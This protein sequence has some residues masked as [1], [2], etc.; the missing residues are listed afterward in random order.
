MAETGSWTDGDVLDDVT[1]FRLNDMEAFFD[2]DGA[3]SGLWTLGVTPGKGVS[4]AAIVGHGFAGEAHI[5]KVYDAR[6]VE[7]D[8]GAKRSCCC[9][10][11]PSS[12]R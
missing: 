10:T 2:G 5:P 7:P 8:R 11:G 12:T 4:L 3:L 9:A 1:E 6:A